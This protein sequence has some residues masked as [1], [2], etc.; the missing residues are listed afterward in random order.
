MCGS[1]TKTK[2]KGKIASTRRWPPGGST[3]QGT[4]CG[5]KMAL[6]P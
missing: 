2:E 3:P 6:G 1:Q 4:G 5:G